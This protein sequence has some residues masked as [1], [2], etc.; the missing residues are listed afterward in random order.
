MHEIKTFS[1][2]FVSIHLSSRRDFFS[3]SVSCASLGPESALVV[4]GQIGEAI[5]EEK[6]SR[7]MQHEH[8]IARRGNFFALFMLLAMDSVSLLNMQLECRLFEIFRAQIR[9][10][11]MFV[12]RQKRSGTRWAGFLGPV[13]RHS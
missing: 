9:L 11:E 7:N 1:L 3:L 10:P 5:G 4:A 2:L 6:R 12:E 13:L 8:R